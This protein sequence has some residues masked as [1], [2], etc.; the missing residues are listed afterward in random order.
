MT[1]APRPALAALCL[2]LAAAQPA[3]AQS[4]PSNYAACDNGGCCLASDQCCPTIEEGCCPGHTPF[5]C[6]DGSC[7]ASPGDCA[8]AGRNTCN[9]YDIPCG[10]GCAPAGSQCCDLAGHYCA[11]QGVCTSEISCVAGEQVSPALQVLPSSS[12]EP[13]ELERM[14]SP[15]ANPPDGTDRSCAF[16]PLAPEPLAAGSLASLLA[17]FLLRRRRDTSRG[18]RPLAREDRSS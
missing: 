10:P 2:L 14:P 11:P 18:V 12:P 7:A 1:H 9:G 5:C 6:G 13:A 3:R 15:I 16:A 17:L 8:S 4:C